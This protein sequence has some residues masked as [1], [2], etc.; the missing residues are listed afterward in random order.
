MSDKTKNYELLSVL[1][2][3][4][5]QV[6]Q[7]LPSNSDSKSEKSDSNSKSEEFKKFDLKLLPEII[8]NVLGFKFSEVDTRPV[9]NCV[10][11][12]DVHKELHVVCVMFDALDGKTY[13]IQAKFGTFKNDLKKL[14]E[15]LQ[16]FNPDVSLESTGIYWKSLY[17]ALEKAG[18][19]AKVYNARKVKNL[20]GRKTDTTDAEWL[21]KLTRFVAIQGSFIPPEE[22]RN[23]RLISRQR[24]NITG[25]LISVKNQLEKTLVDANILLSSV[26]SDIHGKSGSRIIIGLCQRRPIDELI[27]LVDPRIKVTPEKLQQAIDGDLSDDHIFVIEYLLDN[28]K[29]YQRSIEKYD[30]RLITSV[31]KLM[32]QELLLL[33]TIPGIDEIG[34]AMLLVEIGSDMDVFGETDKISAWAGLCPGNN[35][36]AGKRKSTHI[37]KGNPFVR[38]LMCQFAHAARRTESVFKL[39]FGQLVGKK[40]FK[41]SLIAVAHKLLRTVF[42]VIK[43]KKPYKDTSVDYSKLLLK[44]NLPRWVKM[45]KK[46]NFLQ[47]NVDLFTP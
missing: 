4:N 36:S 11:G 3:C 16:I 14:V 1:E 21:A 13:A 10:A 38:R 22:L 17:A 19:I 42:M 32:N 41:R 29:Y 2:G 43:T 46:F 12:I 28:I 35:E 31:K 44:R 27:T 34:A 9:S 20:P 26:I 45:A 23:L 18:I 5:A 33:Q 24:T 30:S 25:Q 15:F 39:K 6:K 7:I 37:G 8:R 47:P 40:G